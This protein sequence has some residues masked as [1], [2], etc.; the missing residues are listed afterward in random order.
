[1]TSPLPLLRKEGSP[2]SDPATAVLATLDLRL[3]FW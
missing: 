2:S 1:M 3:E